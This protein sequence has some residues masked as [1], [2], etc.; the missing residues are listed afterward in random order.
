MVQKYR[1]L[2]MSLLFACLLI[3]LQV[4]GEQEL[5]RFPGASQ[6]L[7]NRHDTQ[8]SLNRDSE[9]YDLTAAVTA[10]GSPDSAIS[11][12]REGRKIPGFATDYPT[13]H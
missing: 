11:M 1:A 13:V 9:C 3:L 7:K 6:L 10:E 8:N 2:P 5:R 12:Q 4:E